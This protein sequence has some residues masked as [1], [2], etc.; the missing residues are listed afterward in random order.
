MYYHGWCI[1][2]DTMNCLFCITVN[3]DLRCCL[4]W[5]LDFDCTDIKFDT[6]LIAKKLLLVL[7][8]IVLTHKIICSG[9]YMSVSVKF[10]QI[11]ILKN[12]QNWTTLDD[13][14]QSYHKYKQ[15]NVHVHSATVI[16]HIYKFTTHKDVNKIQFW[17]KEQDVI[18]P[19]DLHVQ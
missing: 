15:D 13:I 11:Y 3:D 10:L 6:V 19:M 12:Y 7:P 5:L 16:L 18:P 2:S 9:P 4:M 14:W 17:N 8:G 1:S